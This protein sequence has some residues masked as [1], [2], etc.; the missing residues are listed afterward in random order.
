MLIKLTI[1]FSND[2]PLLLICFKVG[3]MKFNAKVA[4][5]SHLFL[6]PLFIGH[7]VY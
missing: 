5:Y 7:S 3:I 4:S 1:R 2:R 6:G